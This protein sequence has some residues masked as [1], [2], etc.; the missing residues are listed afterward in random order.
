MTEAL[1]CKLVDGF[2]FERHRPHTQL[3]RACD[4]TEPK[5]LLRTVLLT[6]YFFRV[7]TVWRIWASPRPRYLLNLSVPSPLS[8]D[9][10]TPEPS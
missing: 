1:L 9:A 6:T 8:D 10:S 7:N 2:L 5:H 3:T 4:D